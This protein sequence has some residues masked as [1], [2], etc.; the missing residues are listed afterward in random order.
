MQ[1]SSVRCSAGARVE[2]NAWQGLAAAFVA[3]FVVAFVLAR[4][5]RFSSTIVLAPPGSVARY[6]ESLAATTRIWNELTDEERA[7]V[8]A[9]L[10]SSRPPPDWTPD[11]D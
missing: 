3:S 2:L 9:L 6:F 8:E 5:L 1:L 11:G 4:W 7:T 10:R